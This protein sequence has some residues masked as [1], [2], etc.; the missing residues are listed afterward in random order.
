M[1]WYKPF[2]AIALPITIWVPSTQRD[3]ALAYMQAPVERSADDDQPH[4]GFWASAR[5]ARAPVS[6]PASCGCSWAASSEARLA[7]PST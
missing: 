4:A 1:Y 7:N 6:A 3:H 5:D 2:I